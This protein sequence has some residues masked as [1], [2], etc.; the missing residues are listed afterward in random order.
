MTRRR[1]AVQELSHLF[2]RQWPAL[3]ILTKGL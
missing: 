3:E 1:A 2:T